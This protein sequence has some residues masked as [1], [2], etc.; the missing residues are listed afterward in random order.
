MS[1]ARVGSGG[2]HLIRA[3]RVAEERV[4]RREAALAQRARDGVVQVAREHC[5]GEEAVLG[6]LRLLLDVEAAELLLEEGV[7]AVVPSDDQP[8]QKSAH[9]GQEVAASIALLDLLSEPRKL[10]QV[11]GA[12]LVDVVPV[13]RSGLELGVA[14]PGA[15]ASLS[16][17]P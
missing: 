6:R 15:G 1:R 11:D 9:A 5:G 8:P 16:P 14:E 4:L 10:E 7:L 2:T 3:D 17:E 13:A 12:A